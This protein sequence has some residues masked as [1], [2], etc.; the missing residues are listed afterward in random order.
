MMSSRCSFRA[1]SESRMKCLQNSS[2]ASQKESNYYENV[3]SSLLLMK[4]FLVLL[5]VLWK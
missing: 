3:I 2:K 5:I 1:N 4:L